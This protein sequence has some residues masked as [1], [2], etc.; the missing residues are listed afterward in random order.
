LLARWEIDA[1]PGAGAGSASCGLWEDR[2]GRP[3][4]V[5]E[6]MESGGDKVILDENQPLY[7]DSIAE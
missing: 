3:L 5:L 4:V 2:L 7:G 1:T 6:W